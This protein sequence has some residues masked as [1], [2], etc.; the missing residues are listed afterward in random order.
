MKKSGVSCLLLLA[1]LIFSNSLKA[2]PIGFTFFSELVF[3]STGWKLEMNLNQ[4]FFNQ[5]GD[6]LS[7]KG[8][9]LVSGKDTAYFKDWMYLRPYTGDISK[10]SYLVLTKDSL[11][12]AL[13]L[14]MEG[15]S[16]YLYA[17]DGNQWDDLKFGKS[18]ITVL[19]L[20][21][22]LCLSYNFFY[23][24]NSPTIGEPND[25]KGATATIKGFVKDASGHPAVNERFAYVGNHTEF[26][27]TDSTG[28]FSFEDWAAST[29][30]FY[31]ANG[32]SHKYLSVSL[33][34]GEIKEVVF[35]LDWVISDNN[36]A[37]GVEKKPG[38]GE[39]RYSLDQNYPNPFN[40]A[41]SISYSI[42]KA[43]PVKLQ[44][45]NLLGNEVATLVN[46]YKN[47]GTHKV[48]FDASVLPS[49]VYIYTIQSGSFRNAKKM[50]VMK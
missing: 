40:P 1:I 30:N 18:G 23:L 37:Q 43:G 15:D 10:T 26:Y 3:D 32:T 12:G 28:H 6:S 17:P 33:Q 49:G 27:C 14:N 47:A 50:T 36:Q 2:N 39:I 7:L 21:Q 16:L 42:P 48:S 11:R 13:D 9:Y 24:D 38:L 41:T 29:Y 35:Q 46:E 22:S 44:V 25:R 34:P 45:F 5:Q 8:W 19:K 31:F 4:P 20:N